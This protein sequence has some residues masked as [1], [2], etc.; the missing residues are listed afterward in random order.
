M[1]L[2]L[3]VPTFHKLTDV[4]PGPAQVYSAA[5]LVQL[6]KPDSN[7]VYIMCPFDFKPLSIEYKSSI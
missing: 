5:A 1:T 6:I 4:Q 2:S 3:Y 7:E